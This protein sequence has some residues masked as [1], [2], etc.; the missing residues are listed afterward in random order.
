MILSSADIIKLRDSGKILSDVLVYCCNQ[1]A[2]GVTPIEIDA[3]ARKETEKLNAKPAFLGYRGFPAS[4][5]ISLNDEVVH[6][7]PNSTPFKDGDI[8][9]L[10]FGVLYKGMYTDAARTVIVG[11]AKPADTKFVSVCKEACSRGIDVVKPG[12]RVGDIGEA[13]QRFV[14]SHGFS[15]V[16]ALVGHGVGKALHDEP[17][18]PNVGIA[19]TGPLLHVG[20]ALAI[21]PM[22]TK[23]SY[24]VMT[25]QNGWT[26]RTRD[27]S[28]A[29][30]YENTVLVTKDGY[31]IIT[32]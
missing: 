12:G 11:K 18:I 15:V 9:S 28:L 32:E 16:R 7:I 2:A 4:V 31:E 27:H 24:E 5:C 8:V 26:V 30:H 25:D 17:A 6:G 19:G 23:G 20:M 14:E 13:V 3:Y 10:D 21:E 1:I 22:I 29:S